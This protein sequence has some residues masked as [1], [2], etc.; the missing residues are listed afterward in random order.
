MKYGAE[1]PMNT[2]TRSYSDTHVRH[3]EVVAVQD[4]ANLLEVKQR[5][6]CK[7]VKVAACMHP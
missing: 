7:P 6:D 4:G 3:A 2:T 5:V 1:Q